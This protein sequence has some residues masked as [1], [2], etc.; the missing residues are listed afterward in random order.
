MQRYLVLSDDGS[1]DVPI[2]VMADTPDQAIRRYCREVQSKEQFLRDFVEGR[3]IDDFLATIL[4]TREERF[5]TPSDGG[6]AQPTQEL[7][8]QKVT[9]YF[10]DKPE[11]G[12]IYLR[13]IEENDPTVL[14]DALYEF[15]SER[16]TS[17]YEA[18]EDAK[19]RTLT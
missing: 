17:G 7:I 16:D 8:R 1:P 13:Y 10:L 6:L 15:I 18:F 19:I 12:E 9:A 2:Y 4:F 3:S 5:N 14:T 11:L